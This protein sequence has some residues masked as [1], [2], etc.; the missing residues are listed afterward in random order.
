MPNSWC[1]SPRTLRK[2]MFVLQVKGLSQTQKLHREKAKRER[3]EVEIRR[4]MTVAALA[5]A[6]NKDFGEMQ[7]ES[8]PPPGALL[9]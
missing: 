7:L 8:A 2:L 4:G 1:Q 9:L 3:Q 5:R 6:M